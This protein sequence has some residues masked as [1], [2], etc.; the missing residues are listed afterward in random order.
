MSSYYFYWD[1]VEITANLGV[2]YGVKRILLGTDETGYTTPA[3]GHCEEF[4]VAFPTPAQ[5]LEY[6]KN[7]D[8]N[9]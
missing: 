4:I 7:A 6:I 2:I 5:A 9:Q 8:K 3:P 1:V